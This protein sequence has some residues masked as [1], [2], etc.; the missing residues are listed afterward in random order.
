MV[1]EFTIFY[2]DDDYDDL[3]FF[4]DVVESIGRKI[5]LFTHDHGEK[6]LSAL[7]NPPPVPQI[8]FLD[9]N[10]PGKSGFE[11]LEE[12]KSSEEL[13]DLPVVIFSTSNDPSNISRSMKMGANFYVTKPTSFD[14]L[15]RAV[16]YTLEIDWKNFRPT[17]AN[18]IYKE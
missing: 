8:I 7:R 15:K 2:A 18:F 17:K 16:E 3:D 9:L 6:I 10:M 14:S 13:K 1:G 4:K 11:V 5:D 12:I